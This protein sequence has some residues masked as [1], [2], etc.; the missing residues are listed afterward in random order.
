MELEL[1]EEQSWISES[2]D[3][4]LSREWVA[5]QDVSGAS[6]VRRLQTWT[7]L[8]EFGSFGIKK[9][10][11]DGLGAV[12]LCLIARSLGSHLASVP[13]LGSAAVRLALAPQA[14]SLPAGIAAL[15][16]S[17]D[18]IGVALLEAGGPGERSKKSLLHGILGYGLVAELIDRELEV[19]PRRELDEIAP[20]VEV[21]DERFLRQDV[22]SRAQR[23]PHEVEA[24]S[25]VSGEIEN[26]HGRVAEQG[27]EIVGDPR[28]REIG[29]A[30]RPGA[31]E[32]A[33]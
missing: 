27:S 10:S 18:P 20:I 2:I 32:I 3:T 24:R 4:L 13:F 5:P 30:P 28:L 14:R 9:D 31:L 33:R 16:S 17:Q 23:A 1:T 6:A 25:R 22:L 29:V 26:A 15:L 11:E 8:V 7:A 12:E 19:A 21:L